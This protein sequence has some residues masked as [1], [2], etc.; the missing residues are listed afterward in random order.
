MLD[1]IVNAVTTAFSVAFEVCG[2]G[3]GL[4]P[5]IAGGAVGLLGWL[6]VGLLWLVALIVYLTIVC[7][8]GGVVAHFQ[9]VKNQILYMAFVVV[10]F[11]AVVL[12]LIA[13]LIGLDR[14]YDTA[15][16]AAQAGLFFAALMALMMLGVKEDINA[17][18]QKK[19]DGGYGRLE[20]QAQKSLEERADVAK[21]TPLPPKNPQ[22][23]LDGYQVPLLEE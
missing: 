5:G 14:G 4:V 12:F 15:T 10:D 9:N 2:T 18:A 13:L 11:C 20:T 23:T 6:V 16:I 8:I 3:L 19:E 22:T 1:S 17:P 7:T 21:I